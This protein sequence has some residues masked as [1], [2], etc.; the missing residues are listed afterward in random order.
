MPRMSVEELVRQLAQLYG[1]E[2]HA[3]ALYGS[4]VIG[5][6]VPGLSDRNVLVLV[7]RLDLD[8]LT[9]AS[10]TA[11]AWAAGGNP[12]PLTLTLA[13]WRR[14]ADVFPMEY[15][16]ILDGHQLLHGGRLPLEGIRVERE[17]LRLELEEQSLGKLIQLRQGVLEAGPEPRARIALLAASLS[18]FM[19]LFRAAVRLAGDRPSTDYEALVNQVAG[20][21]GFAPEPFLRVIGHVRGKQ[22]LS[23][24]EA[25]PV[26]D[27]YLAAVQRFVIYVDGFG[28]P[29]SIQEEEVRP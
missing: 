25:R 29:P 1:E 6:Y 26:L 14:S 12:P 17:D 3:V 18:T 8:H 7:E 21:A 22:K 16:D 10:A 11:R 2:L 28:A 13:E 19:V 4:S 23:L 20:L 9:R 27:G 5:E 15:A 24:Q